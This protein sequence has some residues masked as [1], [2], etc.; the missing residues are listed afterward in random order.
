MFAKNCSAS[1]FFTSFALGEIT[2][3]EEGVEEE[4]MSIEGRFLEKEGGG[5]GWM[6]ERSRS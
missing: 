2:E 4:G 5:G 1:I 3:E 6:V